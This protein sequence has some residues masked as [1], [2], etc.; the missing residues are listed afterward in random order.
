MAVTAR[1]S[2]GSYSSSIQRF[3]LQQSFLM[4]PS[5]LEHLQGLFS[6]WT[7]LLWCWC[8]MVVLLPLSFFRFPVCFRSCYCHRAYRFA[9]I[10]KSFYFNFSAK[11][12]VL[13]YL[14][15]RTNFMMCCFECF[16]FKLGGVLTHQSLPTICWVWSRN[17]LPTG[18]RRPSWRSRSRWHSKSKVISC[19]LCKKIRI[20]PKD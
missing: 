17:V 1:R 14:L 11:V 5:F 12:K 18:S 15:L 20:H 10:F 6:P 8:W 13:H 19:H 3:S 9:I 4:S 16:F 2:I 7:P